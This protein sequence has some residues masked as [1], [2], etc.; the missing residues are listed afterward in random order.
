[1]DDNFV[2]IEYQPLRGGSHGVLGTTT[3]GQKLVDNMR[4][5]GRGWIFDYGYRSRGDRFLVHRTDQSAQPNIFVLVSSPSAPPPT[6][7]PAPPPP[8]PVALTEQTVPESEVETIPVPPNEFTLLSL[9][10]VTTQMVQALEQAGWTTPEALLEADLTTIK[11]IGKAK[12]DSI[13]A[14][15]RERAAARDVL[16]ELRKALS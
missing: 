6:A 3:F 1:M 15:L 7:A 12:A 5:T 4:R 2:L 10:G 13:K 9:P 14:Y 16:E 8:A 11:G